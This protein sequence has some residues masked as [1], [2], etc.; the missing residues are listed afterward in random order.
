MCVNILIIVVLYHVHLFFIW[1]VDNSHS[2]LCF[3]YNLEG[4][5]NLKKF[6]LGLSSVVRL[7]IFVLFAESPH[8]NMKKTIHGPCVA[9]MLSINLEWHRQV[10]LKGLCPNEINLLMLDRESQII[11]SSRSKERMCVRK[12]RGHY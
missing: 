9:C 11:S 2:N 3:F 1:G 10:R 12:Q 8:F 5:I 7:V 4:S 6:K